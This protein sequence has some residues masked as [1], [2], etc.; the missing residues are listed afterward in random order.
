VFIPVPWPPCYML[1]PL[2]GPL[3]SCVQITSRSPHCLSNPCGLFIFRCISPFPPQTTKLVPFPSFF[4][5]FFLKSTAD[6]SSSS[7]LCEILCNSL[8]FVLLGITFS[9]FVSSEN[10]EPKPDGA[11][12]PE[13]ACRMEFFFL[14]LWSYVDSFCSLTIFQEPCSFDFPPTPVVPPPLPEWFQFAGFS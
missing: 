13:I 6:D 2:Y 10:P 1:V 4:H 12:S 5:E 11:H 8:I 14:T 3:L 7:F 9:L